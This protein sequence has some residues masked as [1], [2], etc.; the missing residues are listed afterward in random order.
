MLTGSEGL[1][2]LIESSSA[3]IKSESPLFIRHPPSGFKISIPGPSE[4]PPIRVG[5]GVRHSMTFRVTFSPDAAWDTR[6]KHEGDLAEA[7][8]CELWPFVEIEFMSFKIQDSRFK[9]QDS[10]K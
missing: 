7:S 10:K 3:R 4:S 6:L 1:T 9:I 8:T 5:L 2:S